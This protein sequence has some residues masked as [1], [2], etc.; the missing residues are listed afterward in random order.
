[1]VELTYQMVLSTLQTAGILVGIFYYMMTLRNQQKSQEISTKNQELTLETRQAQLFMNI[2][3]NFSSKEYQKDLENILSWEYT[4]YEDFFSKYGADVNPD[5][6]SIWDHNLQWMEGLGVMVRRNLID[7]NLVFDIMYG[8]IISFYEKF[9]PILM[10]FKKQWG[11]DMQQ[12]LTYIYMEMKRIK[13]ERG[14]LL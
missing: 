8:T 14:L 4:N 5:D 6:H 10:Q 13:E 11:A 1:M 2:F 7:P 9:E 3:N 12:D